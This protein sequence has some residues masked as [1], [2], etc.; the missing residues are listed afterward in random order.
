VNRGIVSRYRRIVG[1][2]LPLAA[3]WLGTVLATVLLA[4]PSP[5][6][7]AL[8]AIVVVVSVW[9]MRGRDGN[10]AHA[11]PPAVL[12]AV[13]GFAHQP[14]ALLATAASGLLL[15]A[16]AT[17]LLDG[18]LRPR[19]LAHRLPGLRVPALAKVPQP[20][21]TA[22]CA[23]VVLLA[24]TV[25]TALPAPAGALLVAATLLAGAVVAGLHL[26]RLRRHESEREIHA[27]LVDYAPDYLVH[28]SGLPEGAYQVQMWL[29]YL[30]R[31]GARGALLVR[32]RTFLGTALQATSLPVLLAETVES[33]EHVMVPD[34]A[35]IFYV[36]NA[37]KNVDSIRYSRVTHVHLGHGDSEKPPSYAASTAMFDRIFV[38]GQAGVD[39]FAHHGVLVPAEKFVQVGRPQVEAI[40]VRAAGSTPDRRTVLY[41]PTWR[42]SLNDMQLSSLD[43]GAAIVSALL[44]AGARVIFRPHPFSQRDA[45][46]RVLVQRID[47]LLAGEGGH[48]R[49]TEATALTIFECMNRSDA[50]VG[51][52]SSVVSDYLYSDKPIAVAHHSGD[53]VERDYP[54]A[55]GTYLIPVDGDIAAGLR[56]LLGA[57]PRAQR[58]AEIRRYY[59][60]PWPADRYSQ[61]FVDAAAR[62]IREG[63]AGH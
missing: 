42:G 10:P 44:D 15:A 56:D 24:V 43:A 54:V 63:R 28:Y 25:A 40:E 18:L 16:L 45:T 55:R 33:I 22:T 47:D 14:D 34:L 17:P 23:G 21:F 39:R 19:L 62:V 27:A 11:A 13:M 57:D 35:A 36:N 41:A 29:P 53:E 50:L 1:R 46:S 59:L 31:T 7:G 52:I 12:A 5:V 9:T 61:V 3:S 49:S 51:D 60:G 4:G 32:E 26:V 20:V 48:L 38:A 30:E 37:A 8:L 6:F 58:R 2:S